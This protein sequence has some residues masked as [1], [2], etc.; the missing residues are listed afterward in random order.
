MNQHI[1]LAY[2]IPSCLAIIGY[3]PLGGMILSFTARQM[4]DTE[5]AKLQPLLKDIIDKINRKYNTKYEVSN[6]K[7][8]I[9]DTDKLGISALG[10]NLLLIN[11]G[12]LESLQEYQLKSNLAHRIAQL[13]NRDSELHNAFL[14][15]SFITPLIKQVYK[16]YVIIISLFGSNVRGKNTGFIALFAYIVGVVFLPVIILNLITSF[17]FKVFDK[18]MSKIANTRANEFMLT[19]GL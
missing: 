7:I 17:V 13:Y 18:R 12:S 10:H 4:D 5:T 16:L 3:S 15:S 2:A 1:A 6:F 19:L 9:L 14:F 11:L 8:K